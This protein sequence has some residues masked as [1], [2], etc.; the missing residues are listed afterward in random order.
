MAEELKIHSEFKIKIYLNV[1]HFGINNKDPQILFDM[2]YLNEKNLEELNEKFLNDIKELYQELLKSHQL[3]QIHG[4]EYM[5]FSKEKDNEMTKEKQ[6]EKTFKEAIK[7]LTNYCSINNA[8]KAYFSKL[9]IQK[10]KFTF[11][12]L[13]ILT[14]GISVTMNSIENENLFDKNKYFGLSSLIILIGEFYYFIFFAN[15]FLIL[16][17]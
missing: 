11:T 1:Y 8:I 14:D 10:M 6:T 2:F 12:K 15:I 4:K 17:N 9:K 3:N 7:N 5:V 13:I 16:K